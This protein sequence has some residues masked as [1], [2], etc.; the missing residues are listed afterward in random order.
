[1]VIALHVE[2]TC[3]SAALIEI[4]ADRIVFATDYPQEIRAREAVRAFVTD[5]RQLGLTGEQILAGNVG[6]LLKEQAAPATASA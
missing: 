4:P 6:V 5:I 3:N 2:Y 1:M